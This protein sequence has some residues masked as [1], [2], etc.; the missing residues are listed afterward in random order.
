MKTTISDDFLAVC[1]EDIINMKKL[2]K[3]LKKGADVNVKNDFGVTPLHYACEEGHIDVVDFLIAHGAD[4]NSTDDNDVSVLAYAVM[5]GH[6]ETVK[7]VLEHPNLGHEIINK[8]DDNDGYTPLLYAIEDKE[9]KIINLLLNYKPDVNI[10]NDDGQSP[11]YFAIQNELYDIAFKLIECGAN[12]NAA[13]EDG[14][15]LARF[16]G[17]NN[18][19][20]VRY[21]LKTDVEVNKAGRDGN[22]PIHIATEGNLLELAELLIQNGADVNPKN[23][24]GETPIEMAIYEY[25]QCAE[26]AREI[27]KGLDQ[28]KT[29]GLCQSCMPSDK[30]NNILESL[31]EKL[32]EKNKGLNNI[33]EINKL[34]LSRGADYESC[35]YDVLAMIFK[36]ENS[37][38]RSE[39]IKLFKEHSEKHDIEYYED[40][41]C[42]LNC[43]NR[44]YNYKFDMT[45]CLASPESY[46][47]CDSFMSMDECDAFEYDE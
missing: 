10:Q 45:I 21:L 38:V 26:S 7:L 23:H 36:M 1:T 27:E 41:V 33:F 5:G 42:Q 11:L 16:T 18:I 46:C 44:V 40:F 35:K 6:F 28:I 3:Y 30:R 31:Q 4:V 2:R 32:L 29:C 43:K 22:F 14:T 19:D 24:N 37:D 25:I 8:Q 39:L 9:E 13:H 20:A 17:E 34:L 12:V 15:L 47:D